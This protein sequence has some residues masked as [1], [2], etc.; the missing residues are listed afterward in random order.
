MTTPKLKEI[1]Y[2]KAWVLFFLITTIGGFIVGA[3]IGAIVGFI[4]G[5]AGIPLKFIA[6]TTGLMG[7]VLSLPISYFSFRFCVA[8]FVLPKVILPEEQVPVSQSA[9]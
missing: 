8:K 3:V 1:D 6:L 9:V 5:A 7:F 2:L 4:L